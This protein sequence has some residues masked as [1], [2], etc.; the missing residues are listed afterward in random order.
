[1]HVDYRA[2]CE[3]FGVTAAEMPACMHD[4]SAVH[5]NDHVIDLVASIG[6]YADAVTV[7][8]LVAFGFL[9]IGF[10]RKWQ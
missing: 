2:E 9:M 6:T 7:V 1:M 8:M 3:A 5:R 4:L 10:W